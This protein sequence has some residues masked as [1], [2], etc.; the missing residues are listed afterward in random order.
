MTVQLRR[1]RR[2]QAYSLWSNWIIGGGMRHTQGARG[3]TGVSTRANAQPCVPLHWQWWRWRGRTRLVFDADGWFEP[4]QSIDGGGTYI[5]IIRSEPVQL[6]QCWSHTDRDQGTIDNKC[7][8]WI[9]RWID[10]WKDSRW[11][12][13]CSV[14]GNAQCRLVGR[15]LLVCLSNAP[16]GLRGCSSTCK[17]L[18]QQPTIQV[19]VAHHRPTTGTDGDGRT[20][21]DTFEISPK[22]TRRRRRI[23]KRRVLTLH[24]SPN[25]RIPKRR[26]AVTV[27]GRIDWQAEERV[28]GWRRYIAWNARCNWR[29]DTTFG[30]PMIIQS[31][32]H[33]DHWP[34]ALYSATWTI[35]SNTG[36]PTRLPVFTHDSRVI[37]RL[38]SG[39]GYQFI[40]V[41]INCFVSC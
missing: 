13:Q 35:Q 15:R 18:L 7:F 6:D 17:W 40:S 2:L 28:Y 1:N 3:S 39:L 31:G 21:G 9:G 22:L 26:E 27:T 8:E 11:P 37:E 4:N 30:A 12:L 33:D 16:G 10:Q 41:I 20:R 5:S 23:R 19:V 32:S 29:Q 38:P 24:L 36:L 34:S 14:V 25:R